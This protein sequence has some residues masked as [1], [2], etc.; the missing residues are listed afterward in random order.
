MK[1]HEIGTALGE[2]EI[3][4]G[5]LFNH[6]G[7]VEKTGIG[8]VYQTELSTVDLALMAVNAL[9]VDQ[10][11]FQ[12]KL[13][14]MVTQSPDYALPANAIILANE[15][16]L[17]K[18]I[19]TFDIN[20]GCSGFVQ[21][22]CITSKLLPSYKQVLLVTADRYRSKLRVSDR[23]TN[24]VF[25]DGA[26]AAI[27]SEEDSYQILFEDHLTAGD[28]RKLLYQSNGLEN[29]GFLHMA[30]AEV[31]LFTRREVVPQVNKAIS[32]AKENDL[33]IKGVYLHQASKLV[34]EGMRDYIDLDSGLVF[35]NYDRLG[36][37]V[38]SSIPF[39]IKDF[40]IELGKGEVVIMAGF[41]VGLTSSVIVYGK[42]H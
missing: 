15:A 40:P 24:A 8:K 37:T 21:A 38:S 12:P 1:I 41:G 5:T 22:F 4:I 35:A 9:K 19:L 32:Y 10:A 25:S 3:S 13:L 11:G 42:S 2:N 18:N 23:S 17:P 29:D 31:W 7:L 30:G 16:G 27:I 28:K 26:T 6:P 34:V 20:Q 14:I 36:N 39:L 33:I